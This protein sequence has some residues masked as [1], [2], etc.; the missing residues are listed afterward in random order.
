MVIGLVSEG[1]QGSIALTGMARLQDKLTRQRLER[2]AWGRKHPERQRLKETRHNRGTGK[3]RQGMQRCCGGNASR[4]P[5]N[6]EAAA[7]RVAVTAKRTGAASGAFC[8][9]LSSRAEKTK[10]KKETGTAI[11]AKE[12]PG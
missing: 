12:R 9:R 3:N 2:P 4:R 11:K 6:H 7:T 8:Q 10:E 5:S 1:L